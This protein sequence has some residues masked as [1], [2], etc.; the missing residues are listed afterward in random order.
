MKTISVKPNGGNIMDK[1]IIE[2]LELFANHG[3]LKE[4]K[5]L[6]QKYIISAKL[7]LDLKPASR[8]D[9]LTKTVNYAEVCN[10]IASIMTTNTYNLIE[11]CAEEI[12]MYILHKYTLVRCVEVEVKKPWAP[13]GQSIGSLSVQITRK[14]SRVY[15]GL[16]ANMDNPKAALDAAIAKM[17]NNDLRIVQC[18][19]Y[20]KTKPISHIAQDDYLNC[21]V[22]A[23]TILSPH[24]LIKHSLQI[25][26]LLGRERSIPLGPRVID[27]DILTYDGVISDD[28]DIIL[29]HSRMQDRL[30]VLVP[31]C[32]LNPYYIHPILNKRVID[33]K[34]DLETKQTL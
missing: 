29:P 9:D 23:I 16:G 27:I 7:Q 2:G 5:S 11:T 3:V 22:E 20:Y 26:S 19:S 1:I 15:L 31:F 32:E 4:E 10:D 21:V 24:E 12:A 30:F 6:G 28:K 13:I 25:E 34:N 17:Q 18:S 8:T 33:L 14:W